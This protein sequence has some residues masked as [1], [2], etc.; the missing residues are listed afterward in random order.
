LD[1]G[2]PLSKPESAP[3]AVTDEKR[4]PPD[5]SRVLS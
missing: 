2:R 5:L 1:S 4:N 3:S